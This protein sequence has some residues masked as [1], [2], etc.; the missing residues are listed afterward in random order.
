MCT[1]TATLP[2]YRGK[3][4]TATTRQES[5]P[6]RC[7]S[8][9]ISACPSF[10]YRGACSPASS[11]SKQRLLC[12]SHHTSPRTCT[13]LLISHIQPQ[14]LTKLYPT[15]FPANSSS[16]AQ[17]PEAASPKASCNAHRL[18]HPREENIERRR[19][20]VS[21]GRR[22]LTVHDDPILTVVTPTRPLHVPSMFTDTYR[23]ATFDI[24]RARSSRGARGQSHI[25]Q[26][27][28]QRMDVNHVINLYLL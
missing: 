2:A 17:P 27:S 24:E 19:K 26:L 8:A 3:V 16:G 21:N 20:A 5:S 11:L 23:A 10:Q 6:T 13:K 14:N 4:A 9:D 12:G 1:A 22:A 28:G 7:V 15:R 18:L 25:N